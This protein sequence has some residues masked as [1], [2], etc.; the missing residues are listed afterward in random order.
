MLQ[1]VEIE[2]IEGLP[3]AALLKTEGDLFEAA[4]LGLL[5]SFKQLIK[6]NRTTLILDLSQVESISAAGLGAL[7]Y[8]R[9]E[10]AERGG[11]MPL[12]S[13]SERVYKLLRHSG[14]DAGL[15]VLSSREEAISWIRKEAK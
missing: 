14:L 4:S 7:N 8:M 15:K 13:K 6:Q 3:Q 1:E 10:L 5:S 2:T 11:Q 12:V 9:L